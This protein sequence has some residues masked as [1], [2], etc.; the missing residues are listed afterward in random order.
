LR[1]DEGV[2]GDV[3][4]TKDGEEEG[5]VDADAVGDHALQLWDDGTAD[6]GGDEQ[7][8]AVDRGLRVDDIELVHRRLVRKLVGGKCRLRGECQRGSYSAVPS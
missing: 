6:D 2:E 1:A 5:V 3:R 7:A 8:G 4:V